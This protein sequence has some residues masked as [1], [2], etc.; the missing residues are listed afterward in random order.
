[1]EIERHVLPLPIHIAFAGIHNLFG[2]VVES[3]AE[4][5]LHIGELHQREPST[6]VPVDVF[7]FFDLLRCCLE[8]GILL[9]DVG[10]LFLRDKL[11]DAFGH[12]SFKL[13]LAF[14]GDAFGILHLVDRRLHVGDLLRQIL[15]FHE[16]VDPEPG[17]YEPQKNGG[18]NPET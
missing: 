5:A 2:C 4:W 7:A 3:L 14:E 11:V 9:I 13:C 6:K 17:S 8:L 1:M 15:L 16:L 12:S 18:N 10:L